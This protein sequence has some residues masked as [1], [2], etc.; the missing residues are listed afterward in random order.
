MPEDG[1]VETAS[2]GKDVLHQW[3]E[4]VDA[5]NSTFRSGSFPSARE[6]YE[7]IRPLIDHDN[8]EW[9]ANG[10]EQGKIAHL[11]D[12]ADGSDLPGVPQT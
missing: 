10:Y 6:I 4:Y 3:H 2:D 9:W 12:G 1:S 7:H 5:I 11:E 8:I